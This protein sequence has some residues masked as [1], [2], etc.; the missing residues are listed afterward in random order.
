M[1]AHRII[2]LKVPIDIVPPEELPDIVSRLLTAADNAD[3]DSSRKGQNIVLLSLWDLLRA[4]RNGAYR[5]YIFSA[6]LVLP[7]SKSI[8]SG[9]KFLTG[10]KVYRYMPFHF[11]I[12][13]LS[14]LEKKENSVYLLGGKTRVLKK[15]ERNINTTFPRLKIVGRHEG[16]MRKREAPA[17]IEAIRKAA[18]SLLLAGRGIRG[19]E[20]WIPRN[21]SRINTGLRLWCSDLF[22][23]F[24]DKKRRPSDAIFDKGLESIVFCMRNPF[25]LFRVFPYFR[26]KLLLLVYKIFAQ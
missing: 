18:P 15:T 21:S 1:D 24:A 19:K 9:V 17:V 4:R 11:V 23:V 6:A 13:L 5:D 8:V 14:I 7:I 22:D 12:S 2:F 20:L 3:K 25:R 16:R 10:K 26:Y